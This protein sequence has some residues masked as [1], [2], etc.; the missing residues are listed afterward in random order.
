MPSPRPL[1][2][3]ELA[4]ALRPDAALKYVEGVPVQ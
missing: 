1:V 2:A 4:T 3:L